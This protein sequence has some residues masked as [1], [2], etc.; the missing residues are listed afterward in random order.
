MVAGVSNDDIMAFEH[1]WGPVAA[2]VGQQLGVAPGTL[3]AQWAY[4]S[5]FGTTQQAQTGFNVGGIG[6]GS[7]SGPRVYSSPAAFG[8]DFASIVQ[9]NFPGAVGTGSD[10]TAY[11]NALEGTQVGGTNA[12]HLTY[13]DQTAAVYGA[14]VA[15][16]AQQL[17]DAG[18]GGATPFVP[19]PGFSDNPIIY[20]PNTGQV[21]ANPGAAGAGIG[22]LGAAAGTGGGW[23]AGLGINVGFV[24]LG[25]VITAL[26]VAAGMFGTAPQQ[27]V[28]RTV[29]KVV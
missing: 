19:A 20:D 18:G 21:V 6:A 8:A 9:R 12:N 10:L 25:L 27:V 16:R 13:S 29:R 1:T 7:A 23:L 24:A 22:Q 17:A 5:N 14:G 28:A 4:E 11:T 26:A 2:D 3:L 15:T